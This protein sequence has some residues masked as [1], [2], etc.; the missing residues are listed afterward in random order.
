MAYSYTTRDGQR[1]ERNVAAAFDKLAAAFKAE[2]GCSLH[3]RSGTRTRAEQ[4]YL[5]NGWINRLPG[6]NLAA[7]PGYSNHEE[8]GPRGPRA[9][10][11]Y[12][13]GSDAGVTT[14]GTKRSNVLV[15]LAK[16]YGFTNAGHYF[17]PKE[18]WHYEYQGSIGGSGSSSGSSGASRNATSRPT[19]DIQRLVGANPDGIWGSETESKVKAFQSSYG[20][21]ADG[22]WGPSSDAVGFLVVDG[23]WGEATTRRLQKGLGVT[24]DGAL[25][26]QTW[27]AIQK[28]LGINADGVPGPI[29]YKALQR[30]L[31][32][33]ADGEFGVASTKALQSW[34]LTG[35]TLRPVPATDEPTSGKLTVDG[36]WGD[37]TTRA[38][39]TALGVTADGEIGVATTSALQTA[40]GISVDGQWGSQTTRALQ[41]WLGVTVDGQIGSDTTTALQKALNDGKSF[42][43]VT[44]PTEAPSTPATTRTPRYSGATRGWTVP[45][46]GS[47]RPDGQTIDTLIIHHCAATSDQEPY[48]KSANSRSSCP[49]WYV[50]TDG[51]V[52]E[53]I[54]PKEKPSATGVANS[55]SVAI[56]TQNTSDDPT[57]GISDES[58]ESIAQIAAWLAQKSDFDG[59]PVQVALDREHVIGH[60]EAGVNATAC[61]GPDMDIDWIVTRAKEIVA[62]SAQPTDPTTPS[63]D[64]DTVEVKRSW[65]QSIFDALKALLGK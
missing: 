56:E 7:A 4:A 34:L 11:L 50:R 20:L 39:Q 8:S 22:I 41:T 10:D 51:V 46:G 17:S 6:F 19:A 28:G 15:R 49:T 3:V 62:A 26:P 47:S 5:Y 59:V 32:V 36:E 29:T 37:A 12:D 53:M 24:V 54:D 38:L 52:I 55:Y 21:T 58:H 30:A 14:I 61:P 27:T 48:F 25:G 63:G 33:T 45:L 18:G 57:W 31:G 42:T 13:S 23:Q 2:T 35:G 43:K 64:D 44:L 16:T 1:V 60:N 9:L 40:L 65:L